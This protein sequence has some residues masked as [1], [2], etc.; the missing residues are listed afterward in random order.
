MEGAAHLSERPVLMF[1]RSLFPAGLLIA[2][3][4]APALAATGDSS[5][6]KPE[7][8]ERAESHSGVSSKPYGSWSL[9]CEAAHTEGAEPLCEISET[10][11]TE[12]AKPI[13]KISV[14]RHHPGDPMSI[15][16]ILPTNVSFPSTVHIRTD[17]ADKWGLE[18]EWQ[19]CIPGAC[20]ATT[21]MSP[22][23]IAHWK[24][25]SSNG[26]IIFRDAAGDEVGLP[27]SL[28]GFGEAYDAF[29]K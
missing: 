18:L 28:R 23:T 13:A 21:E 27:M 10:I 15:V 26:K 8:R 9:R 29:N 14:G 24:G 11:E 17:K 22:A 16:V 7:K 6:A 19:R 25:L 5:P 12:S 2:G 1:V 3:L 20:I 4:M